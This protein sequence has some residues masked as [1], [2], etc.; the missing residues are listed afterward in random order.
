[1]NQRGQGDWAFPTGGN[2]VYPATITLRTSAALG[3]HSLISPRG[4]CAQNRGD[5]RQQGCIARHLGRQN[6]SLRRFIADA[7]GRRPT[8]RERSELRLTLAEHEEISA[9]WPPDGHC[10]RLPQN[11]A[12]RPQRCAGKST[13]TAVVGAIG[14]SLRIGQRI[15]ERCDPSAPRWL[16]VLACV[17]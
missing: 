17:G 4:H 3:P 7:G 5:E 12:D 16:A 11:W 8:P 15:G 14:H 13:P 9:A 1:M 6:S 10:G 2:I